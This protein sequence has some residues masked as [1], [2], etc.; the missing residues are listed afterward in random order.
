MLEHTLHWLLG[1]VSYGELLTFPTL[2]P[3]TLRNTGRNYL[4]YGN[5]KYMP[6]Q[7]ARETARR[8]RNMEQAS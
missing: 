4:K 3:I 7:G 6:H 8:V 5:S 2:R 1:A